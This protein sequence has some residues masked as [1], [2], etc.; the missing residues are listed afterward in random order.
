MEVLRGLVGVVG[1]VA[2]VRAALEQ[3][4]AR[5]RP[6]P[7]GEPQ[8]ARV[9]RCGLAVG[10]GRGGAFGRGGREAQHGVAVPG[11]LGVVGEASRI[12]VAGERGERPA[13]KLDALVG[14][15]RFFDDHVREAVPERHARAG[16]AEHAARQA[17]LEVLHRVARERL[18]QRQVDRPGHD[19]GRVE[20]PS[21]RGAQR[22]DA[23]EHGVADRGGQLDAARGERLGHEERVAGRPAMQ[24]GGVDA[25]RRGELRDGLDRQRRE[26]QPVGRVAARELA[27]RD[28][29]RVGAVELV[30]A[31]AGDEQRRDGRD[32]TA[33]QAEHVERRLVGPVHVLEH[34]DRRLPLGELAQ[35]RRGDRVGRSAV[36]DGFRELAAGDR[37]DVGQ[38]SER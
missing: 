13:V 6:E 10:A 3:L 5:G 24:L 28:P 38:R 16:R 4:G 11:A 19:R 15:E 31:V 8:G 26:P 18:E 35:E 17:L 23:G 14:N 30:V 32:A 1:H 22:L 2:L 37:G 9:L 34:D 7:V 12:G 33:E 20:H 29:Q 21:C 36:G 25:V 27:E